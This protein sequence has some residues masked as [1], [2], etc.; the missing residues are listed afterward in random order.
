MLICVYEF[1]VL[2]W[3]WL[4]GREN[5]EISKQEKADYLQ[6]LKKPVSSPVVTCVCVWTFLN[7]VE[8]SSLLHALCLTV[9][10]YNIFSISLTNI[11]II[12]QVSLKI[13]NTP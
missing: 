9:Y 1:R 4:E 7:C 12:D 6:I 8:S 13:E 2:S 3:L 11:I 5:R 10:V